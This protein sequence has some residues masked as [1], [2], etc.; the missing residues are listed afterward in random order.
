MLTSPPGSWLDHHHAGVGLIDEKS[1]LAHVQRRHDEVVRQ[2]P[3][4]AVGELAETDCGENQTA[5]GRSLRS[6]Q[7][8]EEIAGPQWIQTEDWGLARHLRVARRSPR[9][10]GLEVGA[11]GE[12][13]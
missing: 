12:I 11:R 4:Q 7:Q 13:Y 3:C 8:F 2:G 9:D 6:E 10:A 5:C 1:G